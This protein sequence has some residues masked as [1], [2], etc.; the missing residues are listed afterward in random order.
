MT[1]SI[2]TITTATA[3][4]L[5]ITAG[6]L[7]ETIRRDEKSTKEKEATLKNATTTRPIIGQREE[8]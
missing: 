5:F 8:I 2:G 4:Y 3:L 1:G 6:L 7:S